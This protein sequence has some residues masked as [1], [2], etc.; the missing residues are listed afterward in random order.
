M[1]AL[2]DKALSTAGLHHGS[3][4][5]ACT[6][7][8][9]EKRIKLLEVQL[10]ETRVLNLELQ[11]QAAQSTAALEAAEKELKSTE[12]QHGS[13]VADLQAQVCLILP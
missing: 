12:I 7:E 1:S 10:E 4:E 13:K 8:A 11:K 6:Q 9:A 2:R 5:H 3:D